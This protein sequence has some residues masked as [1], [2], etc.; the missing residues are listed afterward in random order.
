MKKRIIILSLICCLAVSGTVEAS[1]NDGRINC[2]VESVGNP[3][4]VQVTAYCEPGKPTATGSYQQEGVV[5]ANPE[6]LGSTAAVYKVEEDGSIG[7]FIGYYP[8]AD[9]GYGHSIPAS[10]YKSEIIRGKNIG[11]VETGL[12]L[13]FRQ[14][15]YSE[16]KRWM[17]ETYTGHGS[18]G[19]EVY[20]QIIKGVG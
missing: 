7:E 20:V 5:A 12:T 6:W 4:L 3:F 8:I 15:S 19:S 10:G 1:Q 13:D 9:T 11:T 16:C 2:G 17:V 14:K 18:T